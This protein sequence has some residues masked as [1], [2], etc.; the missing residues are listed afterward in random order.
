MRF[1]DLFC[2][3]G[4][5]RLAL[6]KFGRCVFSCDIDED[7]RGIYKQNFGEYPAGDITQ[8][9]EQDIPPHDVL[10]AGFPCQ[11]FSLAGKRKGLSD[12]RGVLF[13][14]IVRIAEY[15]KPAILLLENVKNILLIDNGAVLREIYTLLEDIGYYVYFN[16]LNSS[17]YGIP[18]SR[19][20]VYFVALRKDSGLKYLPPAPT[21]QQI[22]LSDVL[23]DAALCKNLIVK[24]SI[25]EID[26]GYKEP[27]FKPIRIG[28]IGKGGQGDRVYSA[29]G[30]SVSISANM[31]GGNGGNYFVKYD[32]MD[33]D[34][35]VRT[36]HM[37]ERLACMG[38]PTSHIVSKGQAGRRQTGNA[39]V[40]AMI[41]AVWK[42]IYKKDA[43]KDSPII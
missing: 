7:V 41:E 25:S 27:A 37:K 38:F 12:K 14:E 43:K 17:Y 8:I 39:A 2:G 36:L 20:R 11:S 22:F 3:I 6:E 15:H 13:Y 18:Q 5:F 32:V 28:T 42:G 1:I 9:K 31:G 30:H 21:Y 4:G 34:G 40:P 29:A 10:C 35:V 16:T 24:R 19:E 26:T 33:K 23:I